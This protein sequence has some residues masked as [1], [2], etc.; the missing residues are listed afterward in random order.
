MLSL[1]CGRPFVVPRPSVSVLTLV[2]TGTPCSGPSGLP[3]ER[4]SSARLAAWRACSAMTSTTAFRRG[5]TA[6]RR[7]RTLSTASLSRT[8]R[9]EYLPRRQTRIASRCRQS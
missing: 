4:A 9:C 3:A 1:R 6:S 8:L 2:V 7:C 5:L